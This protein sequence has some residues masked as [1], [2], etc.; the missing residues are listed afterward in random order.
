MP[1]IAN[2][3]TQPGKPNQSNIGAVE[4]Q[5]NRGI[6]VNSGRKV[7]SDQGT[8]VAVADGANL[9]DSYGV[10]TDY[11]G[12]CILLGN[13]IADRSTSYAKDETVDPR[14]I[15]ITPSDL[16]GYGAGPYGEGAYGT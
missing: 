16:L 3:D 7:V 5:S 11:S 15:D 9:L 1:Y 13:A 12:A 14:F 2:P 4:N 8:G 10:G 6:R